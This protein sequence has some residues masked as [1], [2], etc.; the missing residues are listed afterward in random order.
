MVAAFNTNTAACTGVIGWVLVDYIRFGF[1]ND[2]R[3][4]NRVVIRTCRMA[5]VIR[6]NAQ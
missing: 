2:T 6:Y 5:F 4:A 3:C 1:S